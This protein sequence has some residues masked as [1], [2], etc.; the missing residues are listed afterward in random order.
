M[1]V[2]NNEL[3]VAIVESFMDKAK[4]QYESLAK[5]FT[6]E[7][8]QQIAINLSESEPEYSVALA[9][10][11]E[12][13]QLDEFIVKHVSSRGEVTKTKDR[14][15]R[16]LRATQTTGLSKSTRRQIA[17]RAQ[18]TKRANPGDVKRAVKKRRKAM[19]KREALG[20]S[21]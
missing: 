13:M 10:I 9:S 20:L 3:D 16:E 8:I 4:E 15:T 11:N 18:K 6:K 7:D 5:T 2:L 14:K 1:I 19:R 21:T 12:E 17:R